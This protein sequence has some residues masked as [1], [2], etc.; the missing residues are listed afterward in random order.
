M[1]D[2]KFIF[3]CIVMLNMSMTGCNKEKTTV[4][5]N[6][7]K[8]FSG[9]AIKSVKEKKGLVYYHSQ[10]ELYAIYVS[11]PGTFDSQD[12]GFI[13]EVPDDLKKDGLIVYFSGSYYSYKEDR[14]PPVAG[15]KYYFLDLK[16]YK[17]SS[18]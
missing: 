12:I 17:I 1:P 10:E 13:C 18:E 15:A 7:D 8:C 16:E 4:G 9:K 5:P 11:I 14:K 2:L 6:G 3:L